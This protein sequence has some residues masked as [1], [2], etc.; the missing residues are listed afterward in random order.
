MQQRALP[1]DMPAVIISTLS[2]PRWSNALVSAGLVS[3]VNEGK[4]MINQG[5]VELFPPSG[6]SHKLTED[7][8]FHA[9]EPG[10]AIKVGRRR[11][12][13]LQE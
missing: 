9:P 3:S 8:Q 5:A 1:E 6:P 12:A 11:F 13:S 10:T 7:A 4:R 2:G